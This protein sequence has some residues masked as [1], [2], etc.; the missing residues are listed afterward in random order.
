MIKLKKEWDNVEDRKKEIIRLFNIWRMSNLKLTKGSGRTAEDIFGFP[1]TST[2][3][4]A[5]IWNC[6]AEAV[7]KYSSE[8]RFEGLAVSENNDAVAMFEHEDGTVETLDRMYII[9]GKVRD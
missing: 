7:Y 6:N 8:W 3:G 2:D 9:I 4:M 1:Y 5:A